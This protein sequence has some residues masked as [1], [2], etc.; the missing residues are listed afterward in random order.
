MFIILELQTTNGQTAH[1]LTTKDTKEEAMSAYHMILAAA[2]ISSVECHTAIVMNEEG[3]LV[4]RESY[5]H[6][7]EPEPE[8]EIDPTLLNN[9]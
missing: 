9:E 1:I 7:T 5:R 4:A 2:A 6:T 3:R 8:P